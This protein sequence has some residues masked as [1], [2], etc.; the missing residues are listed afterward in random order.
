MNEFKKDDSDKC[1]LELVDPRFIQGVGWVL[2]LGAKKYGRA[3]W[4]NASLE[5]IERVKGAMMR[6]Q[7]AYMDG[8]I[9]DKESGLN[10]MYHVATNAMFLAYYDR[11]KGGLSSERVECNYEDGSLFEK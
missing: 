11:H 7:L 5:D 8:E 1:P 10:H 9:F 4:K 2:S 3:N 6:H